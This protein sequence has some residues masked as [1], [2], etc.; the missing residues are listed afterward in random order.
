MI[1]IINGYDFK[2]NNKNVVVYPISQLAGVLQLIHHEVK[3]HY[4]YC[5]LDD[6]FAQGEFHT[7][8]VINN[9]I[10]LYLPVYNTKELIDSLI[11]EGFNPDEFQSKNIIDRMLE[12]QTIVSECFDLKN[13]FQDY[14]DP[15]RKHGLPFVKDLGESISKNPV[16]EFDFNE[17][18]ID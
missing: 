12:T 7:E 11:R 9:E 17:Q 10:E 14:K 16:E 13:G 8:E 3:E 1:D 15:I 6:C 18:S 2:R 5:V 4:F